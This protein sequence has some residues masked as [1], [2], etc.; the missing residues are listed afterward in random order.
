MDLVWMVYALALLIAGGACF[1][2]ALTAL[3][4]M[5]EMEHGEAGTPQGLP[6]TRPPQ[7]PAPR[8]TRLG[9]PVRQI[10]IT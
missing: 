8:L 3:V 6:S 5:G 10:Q 2:T 9:R 1:L 7:E 4:R